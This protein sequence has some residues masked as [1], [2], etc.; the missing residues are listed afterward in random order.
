[1]ADFTSH[2]IRKAGDWSDALTHCVLSYEDRFLRRKVLT[3]ASGETL[4]V[5]L[6][7]PQEM[8]CSHG[9]LFPS[10]G[11]PNCRLESV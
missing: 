5:D 3:V 9:P 4:L 2:T 7:Q 11:C 6:S 1:M 8:G 10:C